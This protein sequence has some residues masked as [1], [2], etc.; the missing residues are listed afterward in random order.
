MSERQ[1]VG[2]LVGGG[3]APGINSVISAA[4]IRGAIHGWEVLGL[5]NGFEHL[6]AGDTEHVTVLEEEGV[7]QLHFQGGSV[8]GTSRANPTRDPALLA[9]ALESLQRLRVDHLIT[10][11][12]D[13]T[14]LSA[15]R[16]AEASRDRIKVVHVPKTIDNDL[17]LPPSIDT[18]GYQTARSVG[19]Q[20]VQNLMV[21]ART[22]RRWFFLIAM[23]RKAGHL[24]LGI[25]KASG[26]TLTL[27]PEEFGPALTP[28]SDVVDTLVGAVI[29]GLARGRR[30]GVAIIAEGVAYGINP[31]DLSGLGDVERDDHGHIRLAEFDTGR[32]LKR[33][34]RKR[35][36]ALGLS[37]TIVSK[38]IGYELRCAAPIPSDLEYTRELGY[39]AAKFLTQGGHGAM[40]SIQGGHFV[41]V[42]FEQMLDPESGRTR[43]RMVDINAVRYRVARRYMHR[44]RRS[45]FE[46]ERRVNDLAAT[47]GI[48]PEAFRDRFEKLTA[49]EPPAL[50]FMAGEG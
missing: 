26:A 35:L 8:L 30:D 49:H 6:M 5:Q 42:P 37:P 44:L 41:P 18:F 31:Q 46:D 13:D 23:G 43:V 45:D 2:I 17:D 38:N 32:L 21:D 19:V 4:A 27:I 12:G 39:A 48:T 40:V 25:G 36:D 22:T 16:L 3:P 15:L 1:R 47:A 34:V 29:T 7:G 24:A 14:A 10:I 11:G 33:E 28:F 20:I 9:K 50:D